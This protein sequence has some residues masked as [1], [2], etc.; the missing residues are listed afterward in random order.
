MVTYFCMGI[1]KGIFHKY[2]IILLISVS[3]CIITIGIAYIFKQT[4]NLFI[5]TE[6]CASFDLKKCKEI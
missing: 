5:Q 3:V 1:K 2:Q 6:S 4:L